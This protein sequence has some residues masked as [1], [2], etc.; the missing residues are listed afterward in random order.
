MMIF[1]E[2]PTENQIWNKKTQLVIYS[3]LMKTVEPS[4]CTIST[5]M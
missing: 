3:I 1:K 2:I 4:N 5:I